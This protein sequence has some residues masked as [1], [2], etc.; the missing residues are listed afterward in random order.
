M[1]QYKQDIVVQP[2]LTVDETVDVKPLEKRI[3]SLE[4]ELAAA[5]RARRRLEGEVEQ[6]KSIL[7]NLRR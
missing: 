2:K 5:N 7:N 1:E 3:R 6:I 4:L